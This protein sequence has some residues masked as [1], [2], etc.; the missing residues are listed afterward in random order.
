M[1]GIGETNHSD[2]SVVRMLGYSLQRGLRLNDE[3]GFVQQVF[4]RIPG[5][6]ELTEHHHVGARIRGLVVGRDD[7]GDI[8]VQ[9]AHVDVELSHSNTNATHAARVR[10]TD[11]RTRTGEAPKDLPR[12]IH[13][14]H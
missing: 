12:H 1:L 2:C 7:S 10:R 6:G 11:P 8:S 13:A 14:P 4:W 5:D 9:I 3:T